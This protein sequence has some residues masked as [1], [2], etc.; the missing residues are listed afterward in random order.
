DAANNAILTDFYGTLKNMTA[1]TRNITR[2]QVA[3]EENSRS[4]H[5][6]IVTALCHRDPDESE[7]AM[8][9]HLAETR[10]GVIHGLVHAHTGQTLEKRR[11]E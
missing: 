3:I 11:E 8:R 1:L 6:A 10:Q 7:R 2:R 5:L 9:A 4:A